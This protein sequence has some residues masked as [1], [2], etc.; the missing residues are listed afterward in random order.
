M[1][2]KFF[3]RFAVIGLGFGDEGKGLCVNSLCHNLSDTL[4]VRYSGGQQAGHTVTLTDGTSHVFSNFGAGT[5]QGCPTYWSKYC[6]FDPVGIVNEFKI[7]QSKGYQP[8]IYIDRKSPVT[9]PYDKFHNQN[10]NAVNHGTCGVGVGATFK[11]EEAFYSLL[12]GDLQ[13]EYIYNQKFQSIISYYNGKIKN[14][15]DVLSEFTIAIDFIL[16]KPYNFV[17]VD[18][19]P[20]YD[21]IIFEGSQGLLLDQ[22]YGFFPHVTRS[23]VGTTNI[24]E[25]GYEPYLYL[26]TRAFQTRHGNGPMTNSHIPHNITNNPLE[27]NITNQYQG[28]FRKSLLDLDL[29]KYGMQRDDYI[30][31]TRNKE[32]VIT[33]LDLI[34]NEYRYTINGK[35][36]NHVDEQSF[37]DGIANYLNIETVAK[38]SSP[39]SLDVKHI[40]DDK[41]LNSK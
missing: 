8:V 21:N 36:V 39:Y 17:F 7:L 13:Y 9:T 19:I 37:V 3:N 32:L 1:Q 30:R 2:K 12:A 15:V 11:R 33:C 10:S 27:T 14:I 22:H 26:V 34:Q 35:I 29:L 16:S 41:C 38:V 31:N 24:L 18:R 25:M 5:F 28:E 40:K 4:V 6:T 20:H 23:N